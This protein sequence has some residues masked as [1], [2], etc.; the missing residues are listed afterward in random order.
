M[1]RKKKA[2][3]K[4]KRKIKDSS[5]LLITDADDQVKSLVDAMTDAANVILK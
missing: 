3:R 1:L 4:R 2:E 5:V